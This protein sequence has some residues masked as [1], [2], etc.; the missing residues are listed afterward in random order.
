M[1]ALVFAAQKHR[2]QRRKD[3]AHSPY[4]NHLIE[5]TELLWRV[6]GVREPDVLIAAVLHDSIEDTRTAPHEI[7]DAFGQAVLDLV[8]EVSDDK[9][10]PKAERKQLQ[11]EHA[12]H[13]SQPAKQ[14]KLADKICNVRDILL[15]PP[16]DWPPERCQEYLDWARRVVA[17]LR[18]ASPALEAEFD[19]L[20][21]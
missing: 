19:R 4:I 10:L 21:E 20:Y 1:K 12:P 6:G 13:K 18:G 11:V 14:I 17:G 2:D 3:P 9:S 16:P 7:R 5:V 8:L 15:N